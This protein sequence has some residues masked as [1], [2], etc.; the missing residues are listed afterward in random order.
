MAEKEIQ[1]KICRCGE[2]LTD[3]YLAME[4]ALWYARKDDWEGARAIVNRASDILDDVEEE[5]GIP[6]DMAKEK[7]EERVIDAIEKKD[8]PY[9]EVGVHMATSDLN[10]AF[11]GCLINLAIY[12]AKKREK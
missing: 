2:R 1:K 10:A 7:L 12:L 6:T 8:R 3:F 11:R 9:M 4:D 5:C